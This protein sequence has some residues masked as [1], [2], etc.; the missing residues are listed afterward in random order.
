VFEYVV[1]GVRSQ[2]H[3]G[4]GVCPSVPIWALWH[5]P[6]AASQV[7]QSTQEKPHVACRLRAVRG[8]QAAGPQQGRGRMVVG[9]GRRKLGS[10]SPVLHRIY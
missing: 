9:E 6:L 5:C 10:R 4:S 3:L 7:A 1:V 8:A 2:P